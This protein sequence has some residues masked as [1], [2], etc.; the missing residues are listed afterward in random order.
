PYRYRA[1][2]SSYRSIAG[3]A[4]SITVDCVDIAADRSAQ[5][6][7]SARRRP[8]LAAR[9]KEFRHEI[10]INEALNKLPGNR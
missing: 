4:S 10:G 7:K 5:S 6:T 9:I 3:E 8:P 2:V 1:N